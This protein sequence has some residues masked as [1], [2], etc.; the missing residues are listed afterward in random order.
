MSKAD[1]RY[2]EQH[3]GQWRVIVPV[4]RALQKKLGKT[5]LKQGLKTDSLKVANMVK[6][7]VIDQL[8]R[9]IRSAA[10]GTP[11]DPLLMDAPAI[12]EALLS[13]ER[14]G[15][16]TEDDVEGIE[17]Y[18]DKLRGEPIDEEVDEDFGPQP[19][20]DPERES[21]AGYFYMVATG[22][23]TPLTAVLDQ[24]HTQQVNRK[25]RTKGDDKR[26][27][28]YLEHWCKANGV[29][30]TIEAITRKVAGR[31]IGDLPSLTASTRGGQRLTNKTANKYLSSLSAYWKW[32]EGR[33]MSEANVWRGQF[34]PK[35]RTTP[36]DR[37]REFEDEE[38]RKLLAGKPSMKALGP[39]MRIAALTG[40][41]IDAIVSLRVKDCQDGRFRFKPQKQEINER[42]V[43]IHS[44][45][46]PL[47]AELTH[48]RAMNDDLFPEFKIPP[49]G[50][51]VNAPH[52][53]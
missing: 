8:Q 32:L 26:A 52:R 29:H 21:R 7:P 31:F 28:E 16:H 17:A 48:G 20:Y 27:L 12:R 18:A 37:E 1:R 53:P 10:Q 45:L 41:R 47:L 40:A 15:Q 39:L 35:E 4:P 42:Q 49:V 46:I 23:A 44:A 33:G 9:Q 36:D 51:S 22:R 34:L 24:W 38:V 25:E 6:G 11:S 19:V 3:R 5:K 2:L 50:S 13:K 43:P 14:L 30:P